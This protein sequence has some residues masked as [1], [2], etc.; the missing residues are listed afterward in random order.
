MCPHNI[1]WVTQV[2][3]YGPILSMG[4]FRRRLVVMYIEVTEPVN[5][6]RACTFHFNSEVWEDLNR[7]LNSGIHRLTGAGSGI[8]TVLLNHGWINLKKRWEFWGSLNFLF[9]WKL[10]MAKRGGNQEL[11]WKRKENK[12]IWT[13]EPRISKQCPE[14]NNFWIPEDRWQLTHAIVLH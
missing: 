7:I 13:A 3:H 5:G 11:K 2:R 9:P 14:K 1:L 8:V 6:M 12:I 4:K 10:S